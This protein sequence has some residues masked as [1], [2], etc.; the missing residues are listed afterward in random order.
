MAN[1][2]FYYGTM[3]VGKTTKLLQDHYNYSK[4]LINIVV[5]KP[6]IDTKG[7][8]PLEIITSTPNLNASVTTTTTGPIA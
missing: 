7:S 5:M 6:K 3:A 2:T 1:L 8:N 4:Y